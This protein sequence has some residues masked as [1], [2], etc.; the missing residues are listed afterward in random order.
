MQKFQIDKHASNNR[1]D[2]CLLARHENWAAK[3]VDFEVRTQ[4]MMSPHPGVLDVLLPLKFRLIRGRRKFLRVARPSL[5][6]PSQLDV[7]RRRS[8]QSLKKRHLTYGCY[9]FYRSQLDLRADRC[10]PNNTHPSSK[11]PVDYA[12]GKIYRILQ[13][14]EKTVYVGSTSQ[15]LSARMAQHRK[16]VKRHPE[17]KLYKLM[18]EV[19]IE[20]FHIE[21]ISDFPC[22]RKEQLHAEEGRH[23][24]LH[25]T[26]TDG[27]N[28]NMAGRSVKQYYADNLDRIKTDMKVYNESHKEV[29]HEYNTKY[30]SANKDKILQGCKV[31]YDANQV[32]ILEEKKT[33][34]MAHKEEKATYNRA[35]ID[36]HKAELVEK[37]KVYRAANKNIRKAYDDARKEEKK[38]QDKIRYDLKKAERLATANS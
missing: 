26:L 32:S 25:N 22:E 7:L 12:N 19:G 11:M 33:Y 37:G 16:D 35:Y 17:W 21:L 36:E 9:F 18:A 38:R 4:G 10:I 29:K 3:R 31:Y 5:I 20:H 13:D 24:R 14:N 28:M 27:G 6:H 8:S 23:I 34:Y 2:E 1:S 15:A 30:Y